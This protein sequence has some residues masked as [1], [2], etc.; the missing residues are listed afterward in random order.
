MLKKYSN[1]KPTIFVLEDIV[2]SNQVENR[3]FCNS[4]RYQQLI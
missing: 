4:I 3:G 1:L 2:F